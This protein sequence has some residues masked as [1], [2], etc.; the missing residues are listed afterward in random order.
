VDDLIPQSSN[1]VAGANRE[2]Y[3]I[4]NV[5][6]GRDYTA[7]ITTDISLARAGDGCPLC[8][9][10]LRTE[11]GIEVG[12]IF[13]LGTRYSE[14][15]G[16]NFL[17]NDGQPKPVVMGSYGI[18][19]GRLLACVAEAHHDEHGLAWPI[20]ISPYQVHLILLSGKSTSAGFNTRTI[21]EN[22]Y[23][24][25]VQAGVEVLF[26]DRDASPGVKFNDAD[27][28]GIPIRLTISE[29]A[30]QSG[31]TEF[32][33]RSQSQKTIIG[34]E[35]IISFVH[36]QITTLEAELNLTPTQDGMQMIGQHPIP[37]LL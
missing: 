14:A 1:L 33:L 28:I 10:P 6:Y 19:L 25:L 20:S 30:M 29:R 17:S 13:K 26:D 11:R 34:T 37:S 23:T 7:S 35:E 12:N 31:G 2:G 3:H 16:C 22:I 15:M 21:A 18:G 8:G 5:N 27:L 32:R 24:D 9:M 4:R 36:H